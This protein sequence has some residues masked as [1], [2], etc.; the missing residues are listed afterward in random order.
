MI[1]GSLGEWYRLSFSTHL[2]GP[3]TKRSRFYRIFWGL[4]RFE[5]WHTR[6]LIYQRDLIFVWGIQDFWFLKGI[7]RRFLPLNMK[8]DFIKKRN[9]ATDAAHQKV[10]HNLW[11]DSADSNLKI[12]V[13]HGGEKESFYSLDAFNGASF[14]FRHF[15]YATIV[16]YIS[17][18]YS[19]QFG[20]LQLQC[21]Q[22]WPFFFFL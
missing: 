16:G 7:S 21:R 10:D 14:F 19:G 4:N 11:S 1:W 3:G 18:C 17:P 13:R 5:I 12:C 6:C 15:M 9:W 20:W 2:H 8:K 22:T